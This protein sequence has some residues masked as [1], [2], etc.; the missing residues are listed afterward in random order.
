MNNLSNSRLIS[1]PLSELTKKSGKLLRLAVL[2]SGRGSNFEAIAQ[3]IDSGQLNAQISLVIYNNPKAQVRER[4]Q[5]WQVPSVLVNHRDFKRREDF[6]QIIVETLQG[7]QVEWIVMAGWMRIVT[8]VLLDAFP[9]RVINIHPSLLP[10]FP[11]IHAVEQALQAGVKITGCTV[12]LANLAVDSGP[13]LIQ[14]AVPVLPED[15]PETLHARI[16]QQEHQILPQAL[17][18]CSQGFCTTN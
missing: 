14:A 5:N 6:D 3:A 11:G 17:A 12:H 10:S 7:Y 18:F 9:N 8:P 4:A 15:T 16:Q 13:I 1:P 2:A